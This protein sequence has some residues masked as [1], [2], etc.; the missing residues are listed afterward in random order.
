V[1]STMARQFQALVQE[2]VRRDL[3]ARNEAR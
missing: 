2:I 1:R 3:S